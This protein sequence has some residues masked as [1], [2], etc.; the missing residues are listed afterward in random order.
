VKNKPNSPSVTIQEVAKKAGVSTATVSRVLNDSDLVSAELKSRVRQTIE[1]LGY[2]PNRNARHLRSGRVRKVGVLF[3]DIS[4]PFFTS[5]LAGIEATL[6]QADNILIL[7]NSNEDPHIEQ[8]HL[9][10][11]LE[12]GVAGIILA[13]TSPSKSRYQDV[14]QAGIPMLTIDRVVEGLK[15]DSVTIN[16]VDAAYQATTHLINLGHTDVAFIGGPEQMSTSRSRQMGYL[17]AMKD[18]GNL[19]PRIKIGNFRHDGGYQAMQALFDSP[20]YPSA[21]VVANNLM[22]LGALQSIRE[23]QLVIPKDIAL[24]G[25]DDVLWVT[26]TQPPLTMIAQPTFEMGRIA[27]R[28]LL[29]R[30]Q[31]PDIPIQRINLETQLIIRNSCGYPL[32]N[33]TSISIDTPIR[34]H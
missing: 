15:I 1:E 19:H 9:N 10:A 14:L 28:L 2:Y 16:N 29:D 23:H 22:T 20:T 21:L 5:V 24:V 3:A 31:M 25:F 17:Q 33:A 7:G 6:Q 18:A 12:E 8:L 32:G 30:I 26:A 4:N 27:A 13:A 34:F 11:F